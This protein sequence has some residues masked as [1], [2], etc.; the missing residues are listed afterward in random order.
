[1]A[2]FIGGVLDGL[3][4][5]TGALLQKVCRD[6]YGFA[7]KASAVQEGGEWRPIYKAPKTDPKKHMTVFVQKSTMRKLKKIAVDNDLPIGDALAMLCAFYKSAQT[8]QR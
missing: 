5:E 1:M 8:N 6:D 7:M 4:M 2:L 3:R